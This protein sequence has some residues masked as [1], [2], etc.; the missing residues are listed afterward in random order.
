MRGSTITEISSDARQVWEGKPPTSFWKTR[1]NRIAYFQWLGKRLGYTNINDWYKLTRAL[2]HANKGALQLSNCSFVGIP[3]CECDWEGATLYRSVYNCS[4]ILVLKDIFPD[5]EWQPWK[6][7]KV[8]MSWW[9]DLENQ[10]KYLDYMGTHELG[11]KKLEDW[12][13]IPASKI[14]AL[15]G[16]SAASIDFRRSKSYLTPPPRWIGSRVVRD[17][18]KASMPSVMRSVYP[19]HPW[20]IFKFGIVPTGYWDDLSNQREYMDWLGKKLGCD[21]DM[22]RWYTVSAEEAIDVAKSP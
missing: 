15:G 2:I 11:V 12:Y 10:R 5:H 22:S 4:T 1:A 20:E 21:V 9:S 17:I 16:S 7:A 6:L 14:I 8:P 18:Y 19:E 13:S 3:D